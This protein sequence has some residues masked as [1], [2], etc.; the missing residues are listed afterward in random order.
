MRRSLIVDD[1]RPATRRLRFGAERI[2][3]TFVDG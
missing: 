1:D 2:P 3:V